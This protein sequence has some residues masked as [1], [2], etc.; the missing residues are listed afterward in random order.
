MHIINPTDLVD[1]GTYSHALV[2]QGTPVFLTGQVAWDEKGGVVGPGDP[3]AQFAQVYANI[4]R[5]LQG[6]N[7]KPE[8]I[9]KIVT[10]VTD[11]SYKPAHIAARSAF[12][13]GVPLPASTFIIVAGLADPGLL[14][15][16]DA[17]LMI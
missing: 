9:V 11:R 16:I 14:V 3:A 5:V 12:F 15:E 10:Y 2:R 4:S 7:A 6:L 17:T 13:A 8:N 1:K